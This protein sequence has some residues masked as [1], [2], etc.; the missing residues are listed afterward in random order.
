MDEANGPVG[1]ETSARL[2]RHPAV[3][4]LCLVRWCEQCVQTLQNIC[5]VWSL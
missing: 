4:Y 1:E 2:P 5:F 3:T